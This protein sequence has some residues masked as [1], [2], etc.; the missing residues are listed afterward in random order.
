MQTAAVRNH[1]I[2][3]FTET[4]DENGCPDR[5]IVNPGNPINHENRSREF[6]L[7]LNHEVMRV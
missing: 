1:L 4:Y 6:G 5:L 3:F 7:I 2:A